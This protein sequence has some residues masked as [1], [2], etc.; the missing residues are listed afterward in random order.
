MDPSDNS[1]KRPILPPDVTPDHVLGLVELLRS[2]GSGIDSMYVGDAISE[3]I[4]FL[5]QA[6]DVA[7]ALGLVTQ[8]G[9]N[10]ELTELGKHVAEGNPKTVRELLRKVAAKLEP[11]GEIVKLLRE[12]GEILVEEFEELL[13]KY[14]SS[15]FEK[16]FQNVLTWGAFLG[17]FK[18]DE[19][20][21]KVIPLHSIASKKRK[22]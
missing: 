13:Q 16:A 18:M 12:K 20:D 1:S 22:S 6:I 10:L 11:I 4:R 17:L 15:D 3:D 21:E 5:P 9:G 2:L 14:Y 8:R 19:D 7:E